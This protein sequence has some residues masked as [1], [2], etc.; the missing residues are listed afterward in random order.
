[1][2]VLIAFVRRR[3][4]PLV[5]VLCLFVS[6]ASAQS[7]RDDSALPLKF[8]M[9][10]GMRW[11]G[12]LVSDQ[13]DV[14][15]GQPRETR[16]D[17]PGSQQ[18]TCPIS[19]SDPTLV[20]NYSG[21]SLSISSSKAGSPSF[22]ESR[23]ILMVFDTSAR[24]IKVFK[25]THTAKASSQSLSWTLELKN[26][27]YTER[28]IFTSDSILENHF[29]TG[30]YHFNYQASTGSRTEDLSSISSLSLTGT[31]NSKRYTA[32]KSKVETS[33]EGGRRFSQFSLSDIAGIVSLDLPNS[34]ACR[35][36]IQLLDPLARPIRAWSLDVAAGESQ[37]HLNVAD[38]PSGVYFLRV[39]A[40]GMEEVRKVVIAH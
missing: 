22:Q 39:S 12:R 5:G 1:M 20:V 21:D 13:W 9:T 3:A 25:Y 11:E 33:V 15:Q 7:I 40:A 28:K 8:P 35:C 10:F 36:T 24:T 27:G 19:F 16:Y 4:V 38:V 30:G 14:G 26:M 2:R 17:G 31:F 32:N 18:D 34:L 6:G 37:V 29:V 23:A